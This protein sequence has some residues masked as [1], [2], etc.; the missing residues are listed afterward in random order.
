[1]FVCLP[2]NMEQGRHLGVSRQAAE[3]CAR[4]SSE[5][6]LSSFFR[7]FLSLCF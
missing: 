1:M 7:S 5:A 4:V 3:A 6:L 2:L